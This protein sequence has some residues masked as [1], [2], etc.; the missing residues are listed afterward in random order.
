VAYV[1]VGDR[2][3]QREGIG[4]GVAND[5]RLAALALSGRPD[6]RCTSEV[7]ERLYAHIR[8]HPDEDVVV[9]LSRVESIDATALRL[10]AVAA[11]R[12]E[13]AGR[14]VVLR[15]C[16]PAIRRVFAFGG[17]RRLFLLER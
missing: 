16:S 12:V 9:D 11:L 6:G 17:W 4:M 7:R 14:R 15:G 5:E 1:I 10:L 8:D 13:R 3:C 2:C